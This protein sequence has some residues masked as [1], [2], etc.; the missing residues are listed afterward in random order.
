MNVKI[1]EEYIA[2]QNGKSYVGLKLENNVLK[3]YVPIGYEISEDKKTR[4]KETKKLFLL[5]AHK[6]SAGYERQQKNEK[7]DFNLIAAVNIL[8]DYFRYGL[9]KESEKITTTHLKGK[10][11]WKKTIHANKTYLNNKNKYN[12]IYYNRINYDA[13]KEIQAIQKICLRIISRVLD[14]YWNIS[15]I[16][17]IEKEYSKNEMIEILSNEIKHINQD[18][19]IETLRNLLDFINGLNY[20][21][22]KENNFSVKY[23]E[24]E[25]IWQRLVDTGAIKGRIKKDYQPKAKYLTF[26][27][28]EYTGKK[29]M[30][31]QPD[32]IY[33]DDRSK[34]IFVLDAKY[35]AHDLPN[36]YDVFKQTRYADFIR[37]I[38]ENDIKKQKYKDYR[39][40]NAFVLPKKVDNIVE[41]QDYF[42]YSLDGRKKIS[43]ENIIYVVYVDTKEMINKPQL[44]TEEIRNKLLNFV[45]EK[46]MI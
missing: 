3:I 10:V 37:K 25:Y 26:D 11:N 44:I 2:A 36:E 27:F 33:I 4:K 29:I 6:N 5:L 22:I 1:E 30:P 14:M 28:R 21:S 18:Q 38:N 8:N 17:D 13:Q 35:Y 23:K 46:K 24:F 20:K 12:T 9:Y 7:D 40:I 42:A 15:F 31:S 45:N 16:D 34:T 39:I 32:T 41:V 19:K 43:K